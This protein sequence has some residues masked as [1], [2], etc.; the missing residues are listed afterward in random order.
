MSSTITTIIES[1]N[2][3]NNNLKSNS[4]SG[5]NHYNLQ[6]NWM[7]DMMGSSGVG[8]GGVNTTGD[9]GQLEGNMSDDKSA[10]NKHRPSASAN[11][12]IGSVGVNGSALDSLADCDTLD[13]P[14]IDTLMRDL[15]S[16][17]LKLKFIII[18]V[19]L[20]ESYRNVLKDWDLWGPL[21]VTTFLA[22]TLHHNEESRDGQILVGPHFAH[23]FVLIWFANV[24]LSLNYKLLNSCRNKRG[25]STTEKSLANNN[26][27][28]TTAFTPTTFQ[29]LCVFGYCLAPPCLG[30]ILLKVV[31]LLT[32]LAVRE[33]FYQ[34]LVVGIALGFV[35]P[36]FCSVRIIGKYISSDKK[37]L[38]IYPIALFYFVLSWALIT[39]H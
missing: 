15:R 39:T 21:L 24:V 7:D 38:A 18:P 34:K 1:N 32:G 33:L 31:S 36:T 29:L 16:I 5:D 25:H 19:S 4:Y 8:I 35:W 11:V 17:Y 3:N 13:E 27:G 20:A 12:T 10:D 37:A 14:I 2:N 22:L 28:N 6:L 23:I 9:I 26:S 30:V